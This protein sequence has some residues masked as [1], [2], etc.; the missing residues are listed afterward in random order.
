MK[1]RQFFH[2]LQESI[3]F[4]I[5]DA[6]NTPT[7]VGTIS[8]RVNGDVYQQMKLGAF[9]GEIVA[10]DGDSSWD[11]KKGVINVYQHKLTDEQF[12]K[13]ISVAKYYIGEYD[14]VIKSQK[15]DTSK[16]Y[17]GNV[18]RLDVEVEGDTVNPPEFNLS[19]TNAHNIINNVLN[20]PHDEA[21]TFNVNELMM[22]I[23]QIRDNDYHIQKSTRDTEHEDNMISFGQSADRIKQIL[24]ALEKMCEWAIA[25]NYSTITAS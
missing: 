21:Y 11:A 2:T 1:F 12:K 4:F 24:D 6:G 18:V 17:G 14:A 5:G 13:A 20:Y 25:N 10:L 23:G 3:T 7:D 9:V 16:I 19:N 8:Y 22:K 15:I